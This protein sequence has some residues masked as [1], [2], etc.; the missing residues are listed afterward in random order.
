PYTTLFRS[1]STLGSAREPRIWPCSRR[2]RSSL[3]PRRQ[4]KVQQ[5]APVGRGVAIDLPLLSFPLGRSQ[6]ASAATVA[7]AYIWTGL[8]RVLDRKSTRLCGRRFSS[9]TPVLE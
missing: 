9:R 2:R 5:S 3:R 7:T 8:K 4:T 1:C 6:R